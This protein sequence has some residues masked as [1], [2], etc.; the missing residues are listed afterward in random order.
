[1][2]CLSGE[3]FSF[4]DYN[5]SASRSDPPHCSYTEHYG[6]NFSQF[7]ISDPW[8]KGQFGYTTI[9][10]GQYCPWKLIKRWNVTKSMGLVLVNIFK[11]INVCC[12]ILWASVFP[13]KTHGHSL[14]VRS[15]EK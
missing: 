2:G 5:P 13:V 1:M 8:N 15:R 6:S 7:L 9:Q 14:E 4:R 10:T 12:P 3:G 11:T